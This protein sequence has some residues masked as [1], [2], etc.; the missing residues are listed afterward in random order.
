MKNQPR[1]PRLVVPGC[2]YCVWTLAC[3]LGACEAAT[4]SQPVDVPSS[5][6]GGPAAPADQT[7]LIAVRLSTDGTVTIDAVSPRPFPW[8]GASVPYDPRRHDARRADAATNVVPA[9]SPAPQS[10]GSG[11]GPTQGAAGTALDLPTPSHPIGQGGAPA[12]ASDRHRETRGFAIV[13]R[14]P[15]RA[16][17]TIVPLDLGDPAEGGGDVVSR[18]Q[19]GGGILR[20][21][22]LGEGSH[23]QIIRLHEAGAEILAEAEASR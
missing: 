23:Y 8:R 4:V 1:L 12:T 16:M 3:A 5:E 20:A 10:F 7:A 22:F 17:P 21:P 2:V 15:S 13:V 19:D 14:H 9:T 6:N 18:W 11:A